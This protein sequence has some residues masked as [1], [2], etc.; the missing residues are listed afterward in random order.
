[1]SGNPSDQK[2]KM[3]QCPVKLYALSTCIHCKNA[4]EFLNQCGIH[5]DCVDVDKLEGEAR[6]KLLEEIKRINPQCAFPTI[7]IGDKV[8]VG[9]KKD[10]LKEILG[11]T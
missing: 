8:I 11:I 3:E 6:S 2:Q 10:E 1:M 5:P 4:K 7:V 9:F